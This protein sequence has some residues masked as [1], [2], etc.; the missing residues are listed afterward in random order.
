MN[1]SKRCGM[2]G[3]TKPITE[4]CNKTKSSDGKQSH[5]RSCGNK[6][7]RSG[8]GSLA[9]AEHVSAKICGMCCNLPDR[10]PRIGKCKCG[11][12]WEAEARPELETRRYY[13]WS[14]QG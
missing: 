6:R 11:L 8:T 3:D 12:R 13:D 1:E 9:S 7:D 14:A 2:C 10:R 4:F 5:C